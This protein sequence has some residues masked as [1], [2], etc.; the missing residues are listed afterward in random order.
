MRRL[1][2]DPSEI[3]EGGSAQHINRKVLFKLVVVLAEEAT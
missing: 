2:I 1:P 3:E